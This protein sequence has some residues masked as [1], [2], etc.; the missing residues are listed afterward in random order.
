MDVLIKFYHGLGD[1][2]QF[3]AVLRHIQKYKPDWRVTFSADK[4]KYCVG[5]GLC[6]ECTNG[7]ALRTFDREIHINWWECHITYQHTPSTKVEK[8]LIE[9][10]HIQPD[11]SLLNYKIEVGAKANE[12]AEQ[13]Y[14]S[15]GAVKGS[16][17]KYNVALLHYEG[18]TSTDRK[19]LRH[20]FASEICNKFLACNKIPVVLDWDYRSPLPD[21]KRI[22]CPNRDNI[23]WEGIGTGDAEKIAALIN[24][25]S[26][27]VGIDSGPGHVAATTNTP[28]ILI[29]RKLHPIHYFCPTDNIIH[30]VPEN[31]VDFISD[32]GIRGL[33]FF[34]QNYKYIVYKEFHKDILKEITKCLN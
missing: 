4:G 12:L 5:N 28:S 6:Y 34:K 13:Y 30:L 2:V 20:E 15:I 17:G 27:F 32:N 24:Q 18:N 23:L 8:C 25:A 19:N 26:L 21:Y 29:W 10:L 16:N 11:N 3:T 22:F 14:N 33:R 7:A 9:E 31:Q 1:C